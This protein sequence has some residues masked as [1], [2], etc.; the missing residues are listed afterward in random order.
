[1]TLPL[2]LNLI[3]QM[4]SVMHSEPTSGHSWMIWTSTLPFPQWPLPSFYSHRMSLAPPI[5][6]N[7]TCKGFLWGTSLPLTTLIAGLPTDTAM[8]GRVLTIKQLAACRE[9]WEEVN[10]AFLGNPPY[11]IKAGPPKKKPLPENTE[12]SVF[13]I[14]NIFHHCWFL[15]QDHLRAQVVMCWPSLA[16]KPWLWPSFEWLWL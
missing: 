10:W 7:F 5:P 8:A 16:W 4:T 3:G 13:N 6:P 2:A 11:L 14:L 15:S 12:L 1:M 9:R